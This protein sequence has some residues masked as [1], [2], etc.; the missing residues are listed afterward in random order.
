MLEGVVGNSKFVCKPKHSAQALLV[1]SSNSEPSGPRHPNH[2]SSTDTTLVEGCD[3]VHSFWPGRAYHVMQAFLS[4]LWGVLGAAFHIV[5][6]LLWWDAAQG[7][8]CLAARL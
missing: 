5:R 3:N 4:V 8:G 2:I 1:I 7:M 6:V